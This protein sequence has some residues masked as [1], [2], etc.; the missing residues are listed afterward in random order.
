[1]RQI[2]VQRFVREEGWSM[3]DLCCLGAPEGT[4]VEKKATFPSLPQDAGAVTMAP[5]Y[6]LFSCFARAEGKN[7]PLLVQE[8]G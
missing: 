7:G 8:P 6:T 5:G 3:R 2:G 4:D 1:M